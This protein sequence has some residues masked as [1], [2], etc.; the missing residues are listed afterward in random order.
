M[1]K[2]KWT[3]T[4]LVVLGGI[5]VLD[6]VLALMGGAITSMSGIPLAGGVINNLVEN[7]FIVF[8]LLMIDHFGTGTV[9]RLVLSI[10]EVPLPLLGTPGF[11]PKIF[12]GLIAG[13]LADLVYKVLNKNK[14]LLSFVVGGFSQ[15]WIIYSTVFFGRLLNIPGIESTVKIMTSPLLLVGAIVLGGTGGLLGLF[16]YR[17]LGN[18][19]I[20]RR[21]QGK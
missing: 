17:K 16:M 21:I 10:I 13:L 14:M 20:V 2:R 19:S 4:Q 12:I 8:C 7:C 5:A 15:I 9:F 3:T 6:V 18:N 1:V 11:T